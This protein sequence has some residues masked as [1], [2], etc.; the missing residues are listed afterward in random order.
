MNV[1]QADDGTAM[2]SVEYAI[3]APASLQERRPR[4]LKHGDTFG[5][6]DRNG[7]VVSGEGFAEGLYHRDTRHLS[8]LELVFAGARPILLSSS[9]RDDNATL[10]CDLTNPDL[11][12]G[13]GADRP[14]AGLSA[15]VGMGSSCRHGRWLRQWLAGAVALDLN[16]GQAAA[17]GDSSSENRTASQHR[18]EADES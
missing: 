9:T 14:G 5:V 17:A 3:S 18:S 13:G 7:D 11:E 8:Q 2:Q 16:Q 4:T 15:G 6:F 10:T 1:I 12:H